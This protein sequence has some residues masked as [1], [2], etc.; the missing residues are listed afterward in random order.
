MRRNART[1][2]PAR[3]Q[4]LVEFALVAPIFFLMLFLIIEGARFIFFYEVLNNATREG[5]RYAIVHGANSALP[6]GPMPPGRESEPT[7]FN[8]DNVKQRV[9]ATAFGIAGE[10]TLFV[11]DPVWTVNNGRGQYVTV[12]VVYEY[13]PVLPLLPPITINAESTL[14]VNN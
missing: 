7:D 10:G 13:Q 6:S 9:A 12:T 2:T 8:G 4:A 3:G 1:G 5:A 11:P 14:V